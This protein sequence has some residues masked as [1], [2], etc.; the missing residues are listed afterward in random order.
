M[1]SLKTSFR[2]INDPFLHTILKGLYVRFEI[3]AVG[4]NM[5][6]TDPNFFSHR[7]Y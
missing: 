7:S 1:V 3:S 5:V 4:R 6:Q 2:V